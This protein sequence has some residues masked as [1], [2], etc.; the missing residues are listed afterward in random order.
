M[1]TITENLNTIKTIKSDIKDAIVT[2]GVEVSDSD[3]FTTYAS[4]IT[5]IP[6]EAIY[7]V[8]NGVKFAFSTFTTVPETIDFSEVA[9]ISRM[10]QQCQNLTTFDCSRFEAPLTSI[11]YAFYECPQLILNNVNSLNTSQC[12]GMQNVFRFCDILD[13]SL[14]DWDVSNMQYMGSVFGAVTFIN[15]LDLSGWDVSNVVNISG[16]ITSAIGKINITGWNTQSVENAQ[17]A[18]AS[19]NLEMDVPLL[20]FGA[21]NNT[22]FRANVFGYDTN[23]Y[24]TNLGGF[25]DLGKGYTTNLTGYSGLNLKPLPNLT[26]ESAM[27]V[28]N[29]LYD[30]NLT[31]LTLTPTLTLN[32]NTYNLLSDEDKAIATNKRW[33]ITSA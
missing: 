6:T 21:I 5:D 20:D 2:K 28:I 31:D 22:G 24:I 18:F 16:F 1:A 3:S 10:F 17:N 23:N 26:Y 29:N 11:D 27:N 7:K 13:T 32:S 25:K 19:P 8:P 9:D 14:N 33:T 12:T 15:D 30:M 4:K